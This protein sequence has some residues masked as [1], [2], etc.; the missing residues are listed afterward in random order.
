MEITIT[1]IPYKSNPGLTRRIIFG[2]VLV[3]LC[4]VILPVVSSELVLS[5]DYS[6]R[7]IKLDDMIK[8]INNYYNRLE[9]HD[10]VTI[11]TEC[12][13]YFV[14]T[15]RILTEWENNSDGEIIDGWSW[16]LFKQQKD[17]EF[18]P[19]V[20]TSSLKNMDLYFHTSYC[21]N[22]GEKSKRVYHLEVCTDKLT[23]GT[24]KIKTHFYSGNKEYLA[25]TEFEVSKD[26][27]KLGKSILDYANGGNSE[28]Y[29]DITVGSWEVRDNGIYN[30]FNF[31]LYKDRKTYDT[32][33]TDGT[34]E[35]EIGK[36]EGKWGVNSSFEYK[37]DGR[38]YLIYTYSR[39]ETGEHCS[40]ICV[41]D[42]TDCSDVEEIYKSEPF[43]SD[44]DVIFV[45]QI[46]NKSLPDGMKYA[47]VNENGDL[48]LYDS[49]GFRVLTAEYGSSSKEQIGVLIYKDGNFIFEKSREV[50]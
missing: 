13:V 32:F 38:L 40:Y 35:Y 20:R 29:Y 15:E 7:K 8:N 4:C 36:G 6:G 10:G 34:Y 21:L 11:R 1:K 12:E 22:P 18:I 3:L 9:S 5:V 47:A 41:L 50:R 28:K 46:T 19:V 24:Y 31:I 30:N 43:F 49:S 16:N 27:S 37:I 33:M 25:E 23:A 39:D 44:S 48:V 42:I 17:G 26:K 2:I 14:G 45:V